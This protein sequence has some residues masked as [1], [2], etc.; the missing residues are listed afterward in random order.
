MSVQEIEEQ[1]RIGTCLHLVWSMDLED[2]IPLELATHELRRQ[3]RA[4]SEIG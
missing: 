3:A 2:G 4:E 1:H